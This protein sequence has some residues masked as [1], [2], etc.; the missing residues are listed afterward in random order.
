MVN[1][2]GG[3]DRILM[4][5]NLLKKKKELIYYNSPVATSD[6]ILYLWIVIYMYMHSLEH[7]HLLTF[8]Y[9]FVVEGRNQIRF[10]SSQ[11][12]DSEQCLL[13]WGLKRVPNR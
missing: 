6:I 5:E 9:S 12:P 2:R 1:T 10:L 3:T 7:L 13:P 11:I 4:G 8:F